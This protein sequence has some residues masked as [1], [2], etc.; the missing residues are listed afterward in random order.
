M[1]MVGRALHMAKAGKIPNPLPFDHKV[2]G[3]DEVKAIYAEL[4]QNPL[5]VRTKASADGPA[6]G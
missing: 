6:A 4:K 5:D 1:G 3:L 2:E